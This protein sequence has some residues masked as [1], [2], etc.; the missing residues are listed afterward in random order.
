VITAAERWK[1]QV[2]CRR[3]EWQLYQHSLAPADKV[4]GMLHKIPPEFGLVV[5]R[6]VL[7]CIATTLRGGLLEVIAE[8]PGKPLA[9][10]GE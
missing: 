1:R 8:A 4:H 5:L 2:R 10:D 9:P 7:P 6:A 3:K